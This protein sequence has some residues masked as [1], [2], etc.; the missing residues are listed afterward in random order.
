MKIIFSKYAQ[1]KFDILVEHK[2]TLTPK[3]IT[4]IVNG[5]D[6]FDL[7]LDPPKIIAVSEFDKKRELRVVYLV[8]DDRI[9]VLSF[10]PSEKDKESAR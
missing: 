9:K 2:L 7:E 1:E 4:D 5:P 3:Q 6:R 10:Y 8:E